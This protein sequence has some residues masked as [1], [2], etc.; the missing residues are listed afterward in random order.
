[1]TRAWAG[2]VRAAA[3]LL[4]GV[5]LVVAAAQ[6]PATATLG[7]PAA[8]ATSQPPRVVPVASAD[9]TCP[10]PETEG[11]EGIPGTAGTS[12]VLAATPPAEALAGVGLPAGTG[13]VVVTTTPRGRVLGQSAVRAAVL[14]APLQGA[15][16]ADIAADGPLAPA[17]SGLQTFVQTQGDDRALV[18]AS[19]TAASADQWLVAGG[20]QSTR[21]EH[22]VLANPGANVVT[23]DVAVLGASG[24]L[25]SAGGHHVAVPPHGRVT[26]LLDALVG[27]ETTP[28]VHVT[29][30]GGVLTA[31]LADSWIDGAVGRGA[32]DA[33]RA[34]DPS[35]E[36]VVPATFVDGPARLRIVAPGPDEAVVQVRVLTAG[37][38]QPVPGTGVVRVPGSS[39]REVDLGGL[40]AGA[41]AVQVRADRPVV[42]GAMVERRGDGRGQSDFGWTTSTDPVTGLAGVPLPAGA[43]GSLML[44]AT[45]DTAGAT[46]VTVTQTGAAET[47][48]VVLSAD[49]VSVLDISGAGQVWVHRT[50]GTLRAGLSLSLGAPQDTPLFSLVP[51]GPLT[52]SAT[53]VPVRLMPG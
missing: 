16:V 49:T 22:L 48:S 26:L 7:L 33:I 24:P 41:Y 20:G 53:Q 21:R 45:G 25:P 9:L 39:V 34:A 12:T 14:G 2:P 11:L 27:P 10:G 15:V 4:T 3:V 32:D 17:V 50:S 52:V 46:V 1:M 8:A 40:P 29:A 31:V 23:A 18:A 5:G 19:C 28:A 37:G 6:V 38:P 42:A 47:R 44:V 30:S 36:Q 43:R 35:T 13:S 51:L